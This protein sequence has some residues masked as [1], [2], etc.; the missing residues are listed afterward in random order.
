MSKIVNLCPTPTFAGG[1]GEWE[2]IAE[3]EASGGDTFTAEVVY[4]PRFLVVPR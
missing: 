3:G 2:P 4:T 1:M